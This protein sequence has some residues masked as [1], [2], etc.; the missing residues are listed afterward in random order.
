MPNTS[1]T[2]EEEPFPLSEIATYV[3]QIVLI[4]NVCLPDPKVQS[5]VDGYGFIILDDFIPEGMKTE[6]AANELILLDQHRYPKRKLTN[7]SLYGISEYVIDVIVN[8]QDFGY[9]T[10]DAYDTVDDFDE[11]ILHW[12]K[13]IS[14]RTAARR[15]TVYERRIA[16]GIEM[17]QD[18]A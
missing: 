16:L 4:L 7:Q 18:V 17:N 13:L 8:L 14:P 12:S 2:V 9:S 3:D 11:V 6:K 1:M 5:L 10:D 15:L